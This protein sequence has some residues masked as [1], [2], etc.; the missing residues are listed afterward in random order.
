MNITERNCIRNLICS[1][2]MVFFVGSQTMF[3]A[4]ISL[5][6]RGWMQIMGGKALELESERLLSEGEKKGITKT[7]LNMIKQKYPP[8]QISEITGLSIQEVE[9][10][11]LSSDH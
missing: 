9:R 1:Y 11:K 2:K 3:F 8:M 7:A 4:T 6:E 5:Q 10:L